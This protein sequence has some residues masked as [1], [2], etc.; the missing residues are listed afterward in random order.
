MDVF[1][2]PVRGFGALLGG[3]VV[4]LGILTQL[5]ISGDDKRIGEIISLY[6]FGILAIWYLARFS[7]IAV[8]L[9]ALHLA[10]AAIFPIGAVVWSS[11]NRAS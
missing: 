11:L 4:L 8:W 5:S 1:K 2:G 7:R 10:V 9:L 6:G 3:F